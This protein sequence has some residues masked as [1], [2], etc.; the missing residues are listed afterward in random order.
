MITFAAP[1]SRSRSAAA[2]SRSVPSTPPETNSA[3]SQSLILTRCG[4]PSGALSRRGEGEIDEHGRAV[5]ADVGGET[6]VDV[7]RPGIR[8]IGVADHQHLGLERLGTSEREEVV[9]LVS[10]GRLRGHPRPARARRRG[11]RRCGSRRRSRCAPVAGVPAAAR[12]GAE[13]GPGLATD[14]PANRGVGAELARRP[15]RPDSLPAGVQVDLVAALALDS[16]AIVSSRLGEKI[17][18]RPPSVRSPQGRP[19]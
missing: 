16:I 18:I 5:V 2:S 15:R 11:G 1:R 12:A 14:Q 6:R 10:R 3:S 19:G 9:A 7:E 13:H 4:L 8:P 17:A